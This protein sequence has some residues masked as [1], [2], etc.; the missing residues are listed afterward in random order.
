MFPDETVRGVT[1]RGLKILKAV[2][3]GVEV[4]GA[5]ILD[6]KMLETKSPGVEV[7]GVRHP[8]GPIVDRAGQ[9]MPAEEGAAMHERSLGRILQGL[10]RQGLEPADVLQRADALLERE[11][12]A[13]RV[14]IAAVKALGAWACAGALL[15][16]AFS[17]RLLESGLALMVAGS[18]AVV[19]AVFCSRLGRD[20]FSSNLSAALLAAGQLGMAFACF[21]L[22]ADPWQWPAAC[23][24]LAAVAAA[25]YAPAAAHTLRAMLI[26]GPLFSAWG[27]VANLHSAYA[28]SFL[29]AA[30]LLLLGILSAAG[31][32][33]WLRPVVSGA[34][35]SLVLGCALESM[36]ITRGGSYL[37]MGLLLAASMGVGVVWW[38][39]AGGAPL[40]LVA[41]LFLCLSGASLQVPGVQC[42]LLVVLLGRSLGERWMTLFGLGVVAVAAQ[43]VYELRVW[44]MLQKSMLL[45][46]VG[47][48]LLAL[49]SLLNHGARGRGASARRSASGAGVDDSV[50][51]NVGTEGEGLGQGPGQGQVEGQGQVDGQGQRGGA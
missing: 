6:V 29:L 13:A 22:L 26:S 42:G 15:F 25:A 4:L 19:L 23:L 46:G 51:R 31:W 7:L 39:R 3:R 45:M 11:G 48:C 38:R 2:R 50:E 1:V 24:L 10:V 14:F 36:H 33:L 44:T 43:Q 30:H 9:G 21:R 5:K 40:H 8:G 18:A 37:Q 27:L 47:V 34:V 32:R 49:W 35:L 20:M 28:D 16:A 17:F 41:I 12:G